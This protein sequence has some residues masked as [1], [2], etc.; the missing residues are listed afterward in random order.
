M[1]CSRGEQG[2]DFERSQADRGLVRVSV[3]RVYGAGVFRELSWVC[4]EIL[5]GGGAADS[6]GWVDKPILNWRAALN[7]FA[8]M[9]ERKVSLP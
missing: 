1:A 2:K 7:R 6:I 8:I 4:E 3:L 9:F 5:E